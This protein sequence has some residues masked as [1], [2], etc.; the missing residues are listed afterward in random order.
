VGRGPGIVG[1]LLSGLV[2]DKFGR[3]NTLGT[4]AA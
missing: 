2:A 4:L 1:V 3:R